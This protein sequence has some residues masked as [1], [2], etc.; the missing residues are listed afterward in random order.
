MPNEPD[1]TKPP[2]S[3]RPKLDML[4][5][6][7]AT[8]I[9]AKRLERNVIVGTWNLRMFGDLTAT[10]TSGP[11]DSPKRNL[12]DVAAIARIL[13]CFDVVAVQEVRGNIRSLRYLL[14]ALGPDWGFILTD[15]N[16]QSG[17]N[18]ERIAF[19]FDGRRVK[20]SG[21][22]CEL[23]VPVEEDPKKIKPEAFNRQFAR[24]PYAVSF[25]SGG[26][27]FILVTLHVYY[28]KQ[29]TDRVGELAAIARWLAGWAAEADNW[30]HNL[31][32]LGD[33]NIDR[34]GDPLY[35]AFTSTGLVP[36]EQLNEVPRTIFDTNSKKSF[37][38]QIAWFIDEQKGPMLSLACE[39]AG[40]FD[41]VKELRGD[42]T[43]QALSFRI[44]DHYPLWTDF[45]LQ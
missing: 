36:A 31:I 28:G 2:H 41:F 42:Q 16:R 30:G 26:R 8:K 44:S 10:W 17:G 18:D 19:L 7:L 37:Y 40:S 22:A 24:S 29:A 6:T 45:S 35:D 33:F 34:R 43:L 3:V 25:V 15:V 38:D 21:L 1:I 14:K 4:S 20:L 32:C 23:V 27:T 11:N 5:A 12:F 13:S 39:G 9:P